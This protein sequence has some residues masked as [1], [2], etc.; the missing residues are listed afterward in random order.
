MKT[1][2]IVMAAALMMAVSCQH[3]EIPNGNPDNNPYDFG[4]TV[5]N[6]DYVAEL[7]LKG[8]GEAALVSSENIPSWVSDVAFGEEAFQGDPV[9]RMNV[10]ADYDLEES[11]TATLS[12]KMSTGATATVE[13]TQWPLLQAQANAPLLSVNEAFEADWSAARR[14]KLVTSNVIKQGI[15]V[16]ETI[17]VALP[18]AWDQVSASYLPKGN[19]GDEAMEVYKMIERKDD[20]SL[21]FNLTGINRLPNYNYFGLYNRYSGILRI[22]YYF[23]EEMVPDNNTS[24]HMWAFSVNRD[25]AEHVATQFAL[26]SKEAATADFK[27]M[28]SNPIFTTPT[29]DSYNPLSADGRNVPAVGWWAFDVNLSA[30]RPYDFFRTS[31]RNAVD[32][33]LCTYNEQKVMLNSVLQG[34][35]NGK[36]Q[37]NMNLE[38][39]RPTSTATWAKI[40]SPILS[41]AGT[42][43]MNT[44]FLKESLAG[45]S[46]FNGGGGGNQ[47]NNGNIM[48]QGGEVPVAVPQARSVRTKSIS[49]AAVSIGIG[50]VCSIAG[51]L[52][53]NFAKQKVEDSNFGALTGN[54][55]LDLNAV[56][57]TRGSIEGRTSNK[58][59]PAAMSM[60]YLKKKNPDGTPTCLGKGVW[61]IEKHPVVYV[62]NDAYWSENNFNVIETKKEYQ[63]RG[64]DVY[65][66]NLGATKGSRPG[67]RLI[68]FLDPTSIEGISFNEELFN[69]EFTGIKVYLSYGVYPGSTPGYTDAFRDAA[70]LDYPHS[71]RLSEKSEFNSGK[72]LKLFKKPHTDELFRWAGIVP[73]LSNV[74]GYR[75]SS[76][77]LHA[78]R[79]ALERRFFGPSLYYSNPYATDFIV[80]EVQF[81]YDPQI[82]VPFED[83]GHKLYDPMVPDL[84]VTATMVAYG[85]DQ[86]DDDTATLIN[87][88]RFVPKIEL[89]SYKKLAEIYQ[90]INGRKN[91][92]HVPGV[93]TAFME[94]NDQIKH[95]EEIKNAVSGQ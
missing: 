42:L 55:N 79:P 63:L 93:T 39:L 43:T 53:D 91:S 47:N 17:D 76:H 45:K 37:G 11:R 4:F 34:N 19:G 28:A 94:M 24:D 30:Y 18:W 65:S 29:T 26:P 6:E 22:F 84:V 52:M 25:L 78:D 50:L 7:V 59:P 89:V 68:T 61:N 51:K 87:T 14:I 72:E 3:E 12:L 54:L 8:V 58:V 2:Y 16:P 86:K 20:W 21:I 92:M 13:L 44:Y 81:V 15:P 62:V 1:R 85:Q 90:M 80:D 69:K 60:E 73:E 31:P 27:T 83:A 66:Y 77:K 82:Y 48:V 35:L 95:I 70:G 38:L 41:T 32:I 23:T 56:M 40:V 57:T 46:F 49:A 75:L 36:L 9:L 64:K 67:L 33:H 5:R 74:E 10:K 88:L 71:W